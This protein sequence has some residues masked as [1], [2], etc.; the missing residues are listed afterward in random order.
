[1][2][3]VDDVVEV[4]F[5]DELTG[6]AVAQLVQLVADHDPTDYSFEANYNEKEYVAGRLA[7]DTWYAWKNPAGDYL[8]KV[9][10]TTYSYSL[11]GMSLDSEQLQT[12]DPMG[13]ALVTRTWEYETVTNDVSVV[14]RKEE[15]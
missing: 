11:A 1:V 5:E 15:V 8:F 9:E 2:N 12:F 4:V 14:I 13:N 10:E 3:S 7:R 6:G